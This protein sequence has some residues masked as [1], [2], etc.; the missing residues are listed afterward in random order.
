MGGDASRYHDTGN[1]SMTI[2]TIMKVLGGLVLPRR[3]TCSSAKRRRCLAPGAQEPVT[4]ALHR[5]LCS[6]GHVA[7]C[8]L[9]TL[10]TPIWL[11]QWQLLQGFSRRAD[12][13]LKVWDI[14]EKGVRRAGT[15]QT[16]PQNLLYC[17]LPYPCTCLPTHEP[18]H[19]RIWGRFARCARC[20]CAVHKV[21]TGPCP[22]CI[23]VP[24]TRNNE[25]CYA[26]I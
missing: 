13:G 19:V 2:S 17:R 3:I 11:L 1:T 16:L 26:F 4:D 25:P 22:T 24:G 5:P 8:L 18:G 15:G 6:R 20:A 12:L 7:I 9:P 14:C 10:G 21:C 23:V